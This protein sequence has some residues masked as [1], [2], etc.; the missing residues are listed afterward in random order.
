MCVCGAFRRPKRAFPKIKSPKMGLPITPRS[1]LQRP[2]PFSQKMIEN[3]LKHRWIFTFLGPLYKDSYREVSKWGSG[4]AGS[5]ALQG[6]QEAEQK[7]L[8]HFRPGLPPTKYIKGPKTQFF[9]YVLLFF[10]SFSQKSWVPG[11]WGGFGSSTFK[12]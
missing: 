8:D 10:V 4:R 7:L 6:V 2:L 1:F 3:I 5:L 9:V 11:S 12:P